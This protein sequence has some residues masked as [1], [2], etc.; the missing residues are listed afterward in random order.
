MI[1]SGNSGGSAL[2]ERMEVIGLPTETIADTGTHGQIG[3]IRPIWLV[4]AH[5]WKLAGVSRP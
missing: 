1:N 5:W 3:Y 2:D 4:P